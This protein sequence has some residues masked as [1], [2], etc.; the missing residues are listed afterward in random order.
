MLSISGFAPS[1]GLSRHVTYIVTMSGQN[2]VELFKLSALGRSVLSP[3]ARRQTRS[4]L[5]SCVTCTRSSFSE[6]MTI[7]DRRSRT[8]F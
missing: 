1:T 6:R 3:P 7:S 4:A 8:T 5:R 2:L